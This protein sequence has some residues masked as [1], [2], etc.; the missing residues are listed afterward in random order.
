MAKIKLLKGLNADLSKVPIIEGQ[1][2]FTLDTGVI[3]LDKAGTVEAPGAATDRVELYKGSLD[4]IKVDIES[5][6]DLVGD[7]SVADQISAAIGE[8]KIGDETFAT[9]KAYVD[10]KTD[11]IATDTA[12]ETLTGRVTT[13]EGKIDT[14]NGDETKEGS[15]SKKIKDSI[16]ALDVADAEEDG[17]YVSSVSQTDG[18]ITVARK[19]LPTVP[20]YTIKKATTPETGFAATYQLTKDD[21]AVGDKINIA[22][23]FLVKSATIETVTTADDPYTGAEVGDKYIDFVIN[24]KDG[25][26]T[27]EHLYLA[28]NDLVDVYTSGSN[29]GDPVVIAV[30][31]STNKI[32]ATITDGTVTKAK[33]ATAVQASLDLADTAVQPSELTVI[34]EDNKYIAGV[35]VAANGTITFEKETLA[36][37]WG[38]F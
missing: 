11:G 8:L 12:L 13:A 16:N 3:Y 30:D 4:A 34:K 5:L 1:L 38:S 37:E 2:L 21:V 24:T 33:L 26:D 20:E 6:K 14:L 32:T 36:L 17:K 29:T 18:K 23:D 27:E 7:D 9:V 25:T 35:T 22:K 10:K 15:V 28:V 31:A 19:D